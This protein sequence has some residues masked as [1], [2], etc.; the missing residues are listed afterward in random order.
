MAFMAKKRLPNE[1]NTQD[2]RSKRKTFKE[3]AAAKYRSYLIGLIGQFK[4][5]P[6]RFWTFLKT[7]KMTKTLPAVLRY[8]GR[9]VT[10]DEQKATLLNTCFGSKFT[11]PSDPREPWPQCDEYAIGTLNSLDVSPFRVS[12][13]LSSLDRTKSCGADGL[14]SMVLQ[15]CADVFAI[16]LTKIFNK[17]IRSGT[18][19]KSGR[20]PI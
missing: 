6:K 5:T 15:Q 10:S 3:L 16:P 13:I 14:S 9:S 12:A 1:N 4:S 2:F 19:P 7:M 20:R 17:C 11:L 18:D 8:E